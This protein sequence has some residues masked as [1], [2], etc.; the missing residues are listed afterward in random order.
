MR[1]IRAATVREREC[2]VAMHGAWVR[3]INGLEVRR[4]ASAHSQPDFFLAAFFLATFFGAVGLA[5][6]D[7]FPAG[8]V[9]FRA[10]PRRAVRP[11]PPRA[12]FSCNQPIAAWR[13]T[14]PISVS[15]GM[16][17]FTSPCL[18]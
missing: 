7:F 9:V 6:A 3:V 5:E 16:V 14:L 4:T 13:V 10:A 15:F 1:G 8:A 18:T 2:F 12:A 11:L 17:A